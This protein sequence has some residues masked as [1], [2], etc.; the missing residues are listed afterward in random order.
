MNV[1]LR[2]AVL[3]DAE[4]LWDMQKRSFRETYENYRDD[5]TTP[6]LEPL[7]RTQMRLQESITRYYVIEE[8]GV[9]VGGIRIR[10]HGKDA[11]KVLGPLYVLPEMR[12]RGIAQKAIKLVESIHGSEN[13]LLDTILQETGNCHLYEKM[14]YRQIGVSQIVNERMTLVLYKK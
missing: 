10:D 9:P 4:L 14:G 8:G 12:G 3:S 2:L 7:A 6:Y 5:E 11:P 13:W 1:S